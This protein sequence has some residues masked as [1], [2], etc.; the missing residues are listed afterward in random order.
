MKYV[1]SGML[2]IVALIHVLP[3]IGV[4]GR[5][6]LQHLYG[7][8]ISDPDLL[9]LM[10]HRAVLFGML[11]CFLLYSTMKPHLQPIAI[12]AG[13]TSVLSFLW[14]SSNRPQLSAQVSRVVNADWIA[15]VALLIATATWYLGRKT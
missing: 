15:L 9:L 4:L 14:L 6:R 10:R 1:T 11:G 5:D 3:V 13:Y 12:V 2:A 7:V 8:D